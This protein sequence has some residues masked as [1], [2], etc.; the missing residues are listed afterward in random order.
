MLAEIAHLLQ[1]DQADLRVRQIPDKPGNKS[2]EQ[3]SQDDD[4][5]EALSGNLS[6]GFN[7][8]IM[9]VRLV[10]Y[11]F[12]IYVLDTLNVCLMNNRRL[13]HDGAVNC[14]CFRAILV[15]YMGLYKVCILLYRE[16]VLCVIEWYKDHVRISKHMDLVGE[17]YVLVLQHQKN[18]FANAVP[19]PCGDLEYPFKAQIL[20]FAV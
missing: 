13:L 7:V 15:K 18:V 4:P 8:F 16:F 11:C 5:T 3:H 12:V 19:C 14:L 17:V 6:D 10:T 2:Q 20:Y 9:R 1:A